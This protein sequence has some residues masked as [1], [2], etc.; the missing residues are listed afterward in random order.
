LNHNLFW[1]GKCGKFLFSIKIVK[2]I[3]KYYIYEKMQKEIKNRKKLDF[4]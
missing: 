2:K 1:I 4:Y 3:K